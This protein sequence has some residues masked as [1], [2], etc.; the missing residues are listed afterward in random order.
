VKKLDLLLRECVLCGG[1]L[2]PGQ[3]KGMDG[4]MMNGKVLRHDF[5][6]CGTR[7]NL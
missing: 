2:V 6:T 5:D 1:T 7:A 4:L 3:E